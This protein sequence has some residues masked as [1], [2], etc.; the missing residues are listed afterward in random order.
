MSE[1]VHDYISTFRGTTEHA[2]D[3]KGRLNIPAR[4]KDVLAGKYRDLGLVLVAWPLNESVRAYPVIEWANFEKAL[5][6]AKK[7]PGFEM[8]V[9]RIT[10]KSVEL[11]VDNNGRLLIPANVRKERSLTENLALTGMGNFFEIWDLPT[12]N[13]LMAEDEQDDLAA[14]QDTLYELDLI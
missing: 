4:F 13:A 9:R 7:G 10:G 11:K 5:S 3:G 8:M 6:S 1:D 12:Y 2:L 14:M